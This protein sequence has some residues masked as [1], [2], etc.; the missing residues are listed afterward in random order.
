M[1]VLESKENSEEIGGAAISGSS[2]MASAKGVNPGNRPV[3]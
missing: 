1:A 2:P 3:K